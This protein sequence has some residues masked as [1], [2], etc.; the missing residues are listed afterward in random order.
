MVEG[1]SLAAIFHDFRI[2][3]RRLRKSP[4]YAG[5]ALLTLALGI[6]ANTMMFS[7]VD[8]VF[9]RPLPYQN[10]DRLAVIFGSAEKGSQQLPQ[11]PANYL[12]L[13]EQT[14][15][16]T[17]I[18]AAQSW[19]PTLGGEQQPEKIKGLRATANLFTVLGV[20]PIA[21]RPFLAAD[22]E[23]GAAPVVLIGDGLAK[24]LGGTAAVIG[25]P[26]RL[27]GVD[28][29]VIGVLP[30]SFVFP[31]FWSPNAQVFTPLQWD[32][33]TR[34]N[35]RLSTL[36]IFGRLRDG[37]SLE[38][39]QEEARTLYARLAAAYPLSNAGLSARVESLAT[40]SGG[41][42][43]PTVLSL[44]GAVAILL[45]VAC[46][47]LAGLLITRAAERRHETAVRIALGAG[48]F[49]MGSTLAAE[50][51]VLVAMG[52]VAGVFFAFGGLDLV[53]A[54]IPASALETIYGAG[55]IQ[56]NVAAFG[57]TALLGVVAATLFGVLPAVATVWTTMA[58]ALRQRGGTDE[59]YMDW[60]RNGLVIGQCAA[61]FTLVVFSGLLALSFTNFTKVNAGFDADHVLSFVVPV[62]GSTQ[63]QPGRKAVFYRELIERL[64]ALPGVEAASAVNH[65]P[66]LGDVWGTSFLAADLPTPEAGQVPNA[67]Y[68]VAMPGYLH[69]LGSKLSAGRDFS[70]ADRQDSAQVVIVN[71]ALA[72]RLWPN[73]SA[74]GK[75]IRLGGLDSDDPWRE[76]IGIAH[77]MQQRDWSTQ[78]GDELYIPF[79]QDRSF[80]ESDR[81]Q[82]AMSFVIR[83]HNDPTSLAP[84]VRQTVWGLA[85]DVPV[86]NLAL[87][88]EGV[89]NA[90]WRP[91][92]ATSV[93]LGLA[94]LAT[95]LSAIGVYGVL[96]QW[97]TRQQRAIGIR[98]AL[99][100]SPNA[101]LQKLLLRGATFA[102]IGVLLG[103]PVALLTGSLA[104]ALLEGVRPHDI[105]TLG[106][107]AM[108][109]LVLGVVS[110]WLPARRAA[111]IDPAEALRGD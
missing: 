110:G 72:Q 20:Q 31:T 24:R 21:G 96:T 74:I 89:D 56:L 64:Q 11:S 68:R 18:A 1:M 41:S 58:Q 6:G 73:E 14:K 12:D 86:A 16:Y 39:A 43:H 88:R 105:A 53:S 52:C 37:V 28:S 70:D 79:T 32:A 26:L 107:A 4:G 95:L 33:A 23:L 78:Q 35:R 108:F 49:R 7:I 62:T 80:R 27:D 76:V 87:L 92:L 57:F 17:D 54:L 99:G 111:G 9:L 25:K 10:P 5:V 84:L 47:N 15:S 65:V 85:P 67:A 36:R 45:L 34:G 77:N 50:G 30:E 29:T 55:S 83:T 22:G 91:R 61:A 109:L 2:A 82:Y 100:E 93:G 71:E 94:L 59:R 97:V 13:C 103:L 63:A 19:A 38:S 81:P 40:V 98:M 42:I 69:A 104:E 102:L 48:A 101:V 106:V 51:L 8:S 3:L 60:L 44:F 75:R 46:A 66:L 90:F